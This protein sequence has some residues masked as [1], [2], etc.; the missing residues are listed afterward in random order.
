MDEKKH[1]NFFHYVVVIAFCLFFR[2]LPG[3]AGITPMGMGLLG[4]FIGA[5]YG[6]IFIDM[7][8]PSLMGLLGAGLTIGMGK[9]LAG[10]FGTDSVMMLAFCM[11]VVGVAMKTG[12]FD[13]LV[14]VLLSNKMMQGRPWLTIWL[15]FLIAFPMGF[16]HCIVMM[17]VLGAFGTTMF[18]ACGVARNDKLAVFY[19]LG[20]AFSLMMGQVMLPFIGTGLV[21]YRSYT[22]MFPDMPM[23]MAPYIAFMIAMGVIMLTAFMLLMRFVFRVDASPLANFCNDCRI[24]P[25]TRDQRISLIAFVCFIVLCVFSSL[26]LGPV[27]EFLSQFGIIG[28]LLAMSC[29]LALLPSGDGGKLADL[30]GLLGTANWG[31]LCMVGLIM[32]FATY[33]SSA[34]AG[35]MGAVRQLFAPFMG[36]SPWMFIIIMLVIA[37]VL[38]NISNNMIV[39]IVILP[40]L[41]SYASEVGLAPTMV[42]VL[43]YLMVQL[44]LATP[45]ASPVAAIAFTQEWADSQAMTKNACKILPLLTIIGIGIGLPMASLLFSILA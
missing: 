17:V 23:Q 30:E 6:W 19:Y 22:T 31:Q 42:T 28:I 44:A 39:M 34:D 25:A 36:L 5:V 29:F 2:F 32:V 41:V 4:V 40:F 33:F 43:L 1:V 37:V 21:F 7:L 10:S 26:S 3:P 9:M 38:T 13:W 8:W 12:A 11:I 14:K 20:C 18:K 16:V 35:I 45:A 15:I 27:S 24:E